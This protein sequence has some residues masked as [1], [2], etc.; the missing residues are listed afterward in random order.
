M[1]RLFI[2][3]N[4]WPLISSNFAAVMSVEVFFDSLIDRKL[5]LMIILPVFALDDD[6]DDDDDT[7]IAC[8]QNNLI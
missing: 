7:N 2:P 6:D 4:F 8:G 3:N 1:Y 5:L